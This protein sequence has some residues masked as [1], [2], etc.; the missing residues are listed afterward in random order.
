ML[1]GSFSFV[2]ALF[3]VGTVYGGLG[4]TAFEY[5]IF[6]FFWPNF[7]SYKFGRT[8]GSRDCKYAMVINTRA[9]ELKSPAAA[10]ITLAC[11]D[12]CLRKIHIIWNL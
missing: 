2:L 10:F 7:I 4:S 8:G 3:I 9:Y 1:S 5:K 6:Y 11:F 12:Q